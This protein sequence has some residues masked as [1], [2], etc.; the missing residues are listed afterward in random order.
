MLI[1]GGALLFARRRRT[2][3]S[4]SQAKLPLESPLSLVS[5]FKFGLLFLG[6]NIAVA[7]RS[8]CLANSGFM[9]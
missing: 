1:T 3:G 4:P 7:L 6:L 5:T 8:V 2:E 9:P